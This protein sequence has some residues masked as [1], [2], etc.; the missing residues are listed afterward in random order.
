MSKQIKVRFVVLLPV[1]VGRTAAKVAQTAAN[2][3]PHKYV[4]DGKKFISHITLCRFWCNPEDLKDI[5]REAKK[6]VAKHAT[7]SLKFK[8]YLVAKDGGLYIKVVPNSRLSTLRQEIFKLAKVF[9]KHPDYTKLKKPYVP[10]VTMV[11]FQTEQVANVV[12]KALPT[13]TVQFPAS[14]I[15]LTNSDEKGQV[16]EVFS[17]FKLSGGA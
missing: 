5:A 2:M 10:H 15:A 13:I 17:R 3:A 16:T 6:L 11:G 8:D 12:K 14:T 1:E 7:V 4:V 9:N